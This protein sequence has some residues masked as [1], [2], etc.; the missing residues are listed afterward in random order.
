MLVAYLYVYI[1][2]RKDTSKFITAII[3]FVNNSN[4]R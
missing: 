1:N 2:A 3:I 4:E